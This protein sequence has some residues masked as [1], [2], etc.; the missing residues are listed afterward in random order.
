[1]NQVSYCTTPPG[2]AERGR[3]E[4]SDGP[5]EGWQGNTS[6]DRSPSRTLLRSFD[7]PPKLR[8]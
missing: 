6:N 2:E 1:M 7:L 8:L 5:G 4:R 3:I